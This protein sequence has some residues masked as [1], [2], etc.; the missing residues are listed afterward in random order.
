M[1]IM[2]HELRYARRQFLLISMQSHKQLE[3]FAIWHCISRNTKLFKKKK[4]KK[5]R[6]QKALDKCNWRNKPVQ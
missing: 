6:Q 3:Q 5:K 4:K 1:L 2:F